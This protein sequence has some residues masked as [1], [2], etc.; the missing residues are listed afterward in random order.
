MAMFAHVLSRTT[1][2]EISAESLRA[3]SIFGGIMLFVAV[4]AFGANGLDLS[5]AFF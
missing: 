3:D 1:G 5:L 2:T 4:A